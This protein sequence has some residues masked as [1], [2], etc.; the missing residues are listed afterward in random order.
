MT[1]SSTLDPDNFPERPDRTLRRGKNV[2]ALGPSDT[3]DS[4]SDV[5]GGPGFASNLDDDQVL[6]LDRGTNED[7]PGRREAGPDLGDASY[8]GDSDYGGTGERATAGRDEGGKEGKDIDTD[9]VVSIPDVP[10]DESD[11]EFLSSKPPGAGSHRPK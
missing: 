8:E 1:G 4:G 6:D 7:S 9:Q 10:L 2:D 11:T 5:V 3:S